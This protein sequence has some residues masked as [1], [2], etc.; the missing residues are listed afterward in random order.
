MTARRFP[1][2]P[3]TSQRPFDGPNPFAETGAAGDSSTAGSADHPFAA[4]AGASLDPTVSRE[5]VC[6]LPDRSRK[7]FLLG[8]L[9]AGLGSFTALIA[10]VSVVLGHWI[11]GTFYALPLSSMALVFAIPACTMGWSDLRAIRA[12]AMHPSGEG[13]TRSGW[14]L[15]LFGFAVGLLPMV[16]GLV[17][18]A[19]IVLESE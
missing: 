5:Y 6:T 12:G 7:V 11:L 10:G 16:A 17:A 15:G 18:L 3:D 9:A 4:P 8:A 2:T 1:R 19:M 13:R 14:R